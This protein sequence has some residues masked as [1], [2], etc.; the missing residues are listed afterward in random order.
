MPVIDQLL[1]TVRQKGGA[2]A[3][4][5]LEP[6]REAQMEAG[7]GARPL[8][9]GPVDAATVHRMLQE[10]VPGRVPEPT[11]SAPRIELR[12]PVG[13]GEFVIS[14]VVCAGGWRVSARPATVVPPAGTIAAP[15]SAPLPA[16]RPLAPAPATVGPP[17]AV[18]SPAASPAE[19]P[20]IEV[21]TALRPITSV[22]QLLV[23]LV[24]ARGSDLHLSAQQAPRRRV[25]GD[26]TVIEGY[27]APSGERL[28]ELLW[29]ITPQRNRDE[30]DGRSDTD[31]AYELPGTGR[32]RVN[33]FRDR[34]GPGAVMR[35]IPEKIPTADDLG[36]SESVRNLAYLSKGLVLVTGP[37]GSGKSTTLAAIVDLI[38]RTR[39][40]HIITIEDPVEFVHP[41]RRCLVNQRE[42]HVHTESF[43][44]ALRAALR[45]D[46]D[47]VLVG[48]LRDLETIAIAIETAET[49]HLVFGTLHTT[50]AISTVERLVDQF[51]GDRQEQVRMMLADS[52]K[53]VIAQTLLKKVGGGRVAAQE[54]LL[55]N[56][57]VSNLIRE[58]KTFQLASAMQT[59]RAKGMILLNDA[60]VDL[61]KRGVV[62]PEEAWLKAVDKETLAKAFAAAN[63]ELQMPAAA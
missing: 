55:A 29:E 48:E 31:F 32:F 21:A 19:V 46:P 60:L 6:G 28:R 42:V 61:V 22:P 41:S 3:S 10:V 54:I 53:A 37:T 39:H 9:R 17:P 44:Q 5:L 58:G 35:Q 40:D 15:P 16:P 30:L 4:L 27:A 51:P 59:G 23:D 13:D 8:T 62:T 18:T 52:L 50:T 36:L 11:T 56:P 43:K 12:H 7:G 47:V 33:L 57:A 26:L 34:L 20:R 63:V 38:N 24:A 14:A 25:D 2:A 49:G 1:Q 45:E